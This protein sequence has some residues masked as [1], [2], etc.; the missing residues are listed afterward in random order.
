MEIVLSSPKMAELT[1]WLRAQGTGRSD[2]PPQAGG[3]AE[4]AIDDE[5]RPEEDDD[6]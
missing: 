2:A 3:D 5:D 1:E 4:P 6:L